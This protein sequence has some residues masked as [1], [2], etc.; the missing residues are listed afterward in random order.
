MN[1]RTV[2]HVYHAA[3]GHFLRFTL[4]H[5]FILTLHLSGGNGIK[6]VANVLTAP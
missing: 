3:I 1:L 6:I 4:H 2:T 5:I